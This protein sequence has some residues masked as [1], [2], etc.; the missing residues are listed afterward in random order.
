MD[1]QAGKEQRAGTLRGDVFGGITA[2]VVALPLAL[3]FG[4][5][6]GLD[7]LQLDGVPISG[8][9]AGMIGAIVVGFLAAV[10]GG[11][12]SQVSGPTGRQT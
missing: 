9:L 6:S 3:G 1:E 10:C 12:P 11:T 2:G 4:V 7:S 5:A 8:A